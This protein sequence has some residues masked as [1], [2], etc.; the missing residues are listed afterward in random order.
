MP[1]LGQSFSPADQAAQSADPN[2]RRRRTPVQQ[3]LQTMN[4]QLPAYSGGNAVSSDLLSGRTGGVVRQAAGVPR[5]QALLNAMMSGASTGKQGEGTGQGRATRYGGGF[6]GG[7]FGD[8]G[9]TQ[10]VSGGGGKPPM[11]P[12]GGG[13]GRPGGGGAAPWL[14]GGK[15]PS[16]GGGLQGLIPG[17]GKPGM[18][19]KLP[20][21]PKLPPALASKIPPI[22]PNIPGG[23]LLDHTVSRPVAPPVNFNRGSSDVRF[24]SPIAQVG[25]QAPPPPAP[26]VV[27]I[28]A[29]GP[30]GNVYTGPQAQG[31]QPVTPP[32]FR[33]PNGG[34]DWQAQQNW[35]AAHAGQAA[36]GGG[37]YNNNAPVAAAG[38]YGPPSGYS[39]RPY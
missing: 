7:G 17:G 16:G 20:G 35:Y 28:G 10:T 37:T 26:T 14:P 39:G 25:P 29:A 8:S 12:A 11:A 24:N 1:D 38:S 2:L 3:A 32:S 22:N 19:P 9:G 4:L 31:P 21:V 6:G 18:M 15:L 13:G 5:T 30:N 23:G 36:P 27:P 33:L 34:T